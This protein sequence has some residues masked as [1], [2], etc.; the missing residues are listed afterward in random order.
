MDGRCLKLKQLVGTTQELLNNWM[1]QVGQPKKKGPVLLSY[2][3]YCGVYYHVL[4]DS[5]YHIVP[6][7]RSISDHVSGRLHVLE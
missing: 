2:K 6:L 3:L 4:S 7:A 5:S 1:F